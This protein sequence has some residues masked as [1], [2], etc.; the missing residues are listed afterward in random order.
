VTA[1]PPSRQEVSP[2]DESNAP[3]EEQEKP[4]EEIQP[5]TTFAAELVG[6][7]KVRWWQAVLP[8]LLA[9]CTALVIGGLV[10]I[11]TEREALSQWKSFFRDPGDAFSVSWRVVSDAYYA[12]FSGSFG[13]PSRLA[14][15]F[16]SGELDQIR[17]ALFP[18]SETI[19][20]ATPLIFVGLSVALGFRAGL[21]NI[22][23]EG[24]M[25]AGAIVAAAAGISFGWL[26]G[27]V[28]LAF[29]VIAGLLGGA[30][31][32]A[33]PG[34]LKA[35][36]GAHE[37]IT[38]IMLN[39][40]AVSL[41]LYVLSTSLYKQQ[42]EPISKPVKVAFPHLFG[43]NLR[44]HVG[45]LLALG[46]AALVGWLLNR[47]TIGFE[48][49]AV[50]ANPSAARAAGM[51]PAR[52]VIVVMAIAGGLAGLAGA[53]QLGGVTPSL[54]P[55]FASGLGFDGIALAMLGRGTPLGVVLSAFLFG[56]LRAGG[57]TMQA[58]TQTPID[59][60]VII[61]GLVILFVAAPALV[62]AIYRI[63]ARRVA[64]PEAFAK[65]W[66]G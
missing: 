56:A 12:L 64:G 34:F 29:M 33:I 49:R 46:V 23:A 59:L 32:G 11:F 2:V 60:I 22:G 20:T 27:P 18:L 1:T 55:G 37:V 35:K 47:T 15:A 21:F 62:R 53:N 42:A 50:G 61:Q 58:V 13:S 51:N 6:P 4:V 38:T 63:K 48:F 52:T 30:I 57:R 36:T 25:N 8:P 43:A 3:V 39:F 40:I 44:V 26:P 66:G 14:R 65:G 16:G 24:Q 45:I 10:I 17:E 9:I 28:H 5:E 19:V 7:A 41:T 54:I 31:W